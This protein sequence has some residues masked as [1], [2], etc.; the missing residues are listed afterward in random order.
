M[1]GE[2]FPAEAEGGKEGTEGRGLVGG[3]PLHRDS[4][5]EEISMHAASSV[6]FGP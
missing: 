2:E 1:R 4:T 5:H 3:N 6:A